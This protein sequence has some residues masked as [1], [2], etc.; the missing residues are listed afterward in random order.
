MK[1]FLFKSTGV[2]PGGLDDLQNWSCKEVN[3]IEF[4]VISRPDGEV[5]CLRWSAGDV[6][7]RKPGFELPLDAVSSA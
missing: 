6:G 1:R 3:E 5:I 2:P 7:K 4:R